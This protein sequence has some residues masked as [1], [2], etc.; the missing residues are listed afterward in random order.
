MAWKPSATDCSSMTFMATASGPARA[1]ARLQVA[2][3]RLGELRVQVGQ[4]DVPALCDKVGGDGQPEPLG[5][6]R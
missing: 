3:I 6:A 5:C 2:G 4:D 1:M